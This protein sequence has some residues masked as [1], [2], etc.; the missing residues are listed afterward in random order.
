M[1]VPP[2]RIVITL[3]SAFAFFATAGGAFA[4]THH[5][6]KAHAKHHVAKAQVNAKRMF[7]MD[8]A[9]PAAPTGLAVKSASASSITFSWRVTR[10]NLTVAYYRVYVNGAPAG[11]TRL[12]SYSVRGLK[13]GTSYLLGVDSVDFRL[14]RSS[15]SAIVASTSPCAAPPAS[16][17]APAPPAQSPAP[18][19]PP[20]DTQAPTV[21]TG[22]T[23]TTS[24]VAAITLTWQASKDNVGV[25]SYGVYLN[26]KRVGS[27]SATTY[28]FSGLAC[29]ETYS[30]GVDASDAAGNTSSQ[31]QSNVS[32]SACPDTLAPLAPSNLLAATITQTSVTL[33]WQASIDNV[34]VAGYGV[35]LQGTRVTNVAATGYTYTGLTCG[36]AYQLGVDAYDAAGNRS[37]QST[38]STTTMACA[39]NQA[40]TAPSNLSVSSVT[41]TSLSLSW[42]AATD[43]TGVTGY[44]AYLNGAQAG[45]TTGTSYGFSGL[46]CGTA[47][48]LGVEAR[49]GSGNVS[50]RPTASGTTAACSSPSPPP[51]TT[52][53]APPAPPTT[54]PSPTP[55]PPSSANVYLSTSG[56]DSTCARNNSSKPCATFNRAYQI[57]NTGDTVLVSAGQYPY[58]S[59]SQGSNY[60]DP[61][62]SKSGVVT[63][64]C[65]G[66]GDV[67]FAAPSFDFHPG[68]DGVAMVG[69]CFHFHQ[70]Q[71]GFGGYIAQTKDI[72]LDGVHMETFNCAGCANLTI[73][74]SEV[75]PLL[76][77]YASGDGFSAPSYA[78]CNASASPA[79][80]YWAQHGGTSGI[81]QEPFI[82]DGGGH[83]ATNIVLDNDHIHGISSRWASTHT[84]GLI[85]WNVNG[86][87]ISN[88]TFDHNVIYDV[89]DN[90]GSQDN[91][92]TFSNDTFGVP[93]Y[94]LDPTEPNPGGPLP[95]GF[96]EMT[97]GGNGDA[98]SNW[99]I[100]RSSFVNGL[101]FGTTGGGTYSNV[102]VTNSNLGSSTICVG[103]AG[104]TWS[105]NTSCG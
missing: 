70:V 90:Q 53:P 24:T 59:V 74:N 33:S 81:Q 71:F 50:S 87:T 78:L 75:G 20:T 103:V 42:S 10:S 86:L 63:F 76:A 69:G 1:R 51:T 22:L 40:P 27:P 92:V 55:P 49:D 47:Y 16:S 11:T 62:S 13:C 95:Y 38:I 57:A 5:A 4:Q 88:T 7:L 61:D 91:N 48:T 64:A 89:F 52:S 99:V 25:L 77:C 82:H 85:I 14:T 67:S 36:K 35:Y 98:L 3:V 100:D 97:V 19:A 96:R 84:G 44:T 31:A 28:T 39:D 45:Q 17:P 102:K 32:T 30:V 83:T 60:I 29:G 23:E 6:P 12:A 21:P 104:I 79:E 56:S 41:Q 37:S 65:Q 66:N 73:R 105:G 101:L 9:D 26:G 18:P 15:R 94:S 68:L 8:T 43:N 46:T 80:A 2:Q 58:D 34:G 93:V 54:N 72:T